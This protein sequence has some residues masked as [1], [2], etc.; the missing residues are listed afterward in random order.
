[1]K[2]LST[3]ALSLRCWEFIVACVLSEKRRD[4]VVVDL[5]AETWQETRQLRYYR[6]LL[7]AG[8]AEIMPS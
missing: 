8:H 6:P 3:P 1:M 2:D 5:Q 4:A 7:E